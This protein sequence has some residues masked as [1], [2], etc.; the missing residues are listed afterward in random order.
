MDRLNFCEVGGHV[1]FKFSSE[2]FELRR[3]L[4]DTPDIKLHFNAPVAAMVQISK[5][6]TDGKEPTDASSAVC[7]STTKGEIE[8]ERCA[9]EI[10][11]ALSTSL[12]GRWANFRAIESSRMPT[13]YASIDRFFSPLITLTESTISILRWRCGLPEGPADPFHHRSEH[14]SQD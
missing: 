6:Y 1:D 5:N 3:H 11:A 14:L 12:A 10:Q 13:V 9:A 2:I 7:V 4:P 8:D